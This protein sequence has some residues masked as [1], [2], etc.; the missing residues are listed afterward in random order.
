[1]SLT[2]KSGIITIQNATNQTK[3]TSSD[4]LVYQKAYTSGGPIVLS[5]AASSI[6]IPFSPMG[7]NDFLVVAV[8]FSYIGTESPAYADIASST[9]NKWLPANG[10]IMVNIFP[11]QVGNDAYCSSQSFGVSLIEDTLFFKRTKY[12]SD[13]YINYGGG[14]SNGDPNGVELI[15]TYI[16]R[17]LSYL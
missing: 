6:A 4:R 7:P 11:R 16:V 3:F 10:S 12:A 9:I 15:F 8:N 14:L 1:M 17:L 13:G 2:V 5:S